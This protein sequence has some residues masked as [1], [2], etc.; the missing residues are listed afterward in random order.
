MFMT[1][2]KQEYL[3]HFISSQKLDYLARH[4]KKPLNQNDTSRC[5]KV[6]SKS[7]SDKF[8]SKNHEIITF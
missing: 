4:P 1:P 7:I 8:Q 6:N 3:K 2:K 5:E